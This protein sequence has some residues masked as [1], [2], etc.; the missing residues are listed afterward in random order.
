MVT[1]LYNYLYDIKETL[2]DKK[3][4][5]M[6]E[7]ALIIGLVAVL[8]IAGLTA[9]KGGIAGTFTKITTELTKP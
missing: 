5:G 2:K 3:G 6:V 7:Y 1:R 4:Q 8:L 9:L